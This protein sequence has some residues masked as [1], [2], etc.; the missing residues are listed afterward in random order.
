MGHMATKQD[1]GSR[2]TIA[3]PENRADTFGKE[4]GSG[5]GRSK[6]RGLHSGRAGP[7]EQ[8]HERQGDPHSQHAPRMNV[9][10][11]A[12][13]QM[14]SDRFRTDGPPVTRMEE[15]EIKND[16][17]RLAYVGTPSYKVDR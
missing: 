4:N 14:F 11:S 8:D 6:D 9:G 16:R 15:P 5:A 13:S 1:E 3:G 12:A 10:R 7:P 2:D 17:V